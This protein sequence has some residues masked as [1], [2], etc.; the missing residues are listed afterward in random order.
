MTERPEFRP[1]LSNDDLLCIISQQGAGS[2]E[3]SVWRAL[4]ARFGREIDIDWVKERLSKLMAAG[5]AVY[6]PSLFRA[7]GPSESDTKVQLTALGV[8]RL[9][10]LQREP[11]APP[12]E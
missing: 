3:L 7:S 4:N 2:T 11:I 12:T 8:E 5:L 1:K 10:A 6:A 9:C